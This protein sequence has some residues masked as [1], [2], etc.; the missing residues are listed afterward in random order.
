[1]HWN[2]SEDTL[3]TYRSEQPRS[4]T[5]AVLNTISDHTGVDLLAPDFC[6]YDDIDPEALNRLFES[7]AISELVVAFSTDSVRVELRNH[8]ELEIRVSDRVPA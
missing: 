3:Q 6:L 5:D 7:D 8:G 2:I 1:M 4:V